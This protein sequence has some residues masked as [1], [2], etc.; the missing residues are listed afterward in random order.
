MGVYGKLLKK[1]YTPPPQQTQPPELPESPEDRKTPVP[2]PLPY[3]HPQPEQHNTPDTVIPRHRD[4]NVD[5]TTPSNHDT[6][7]PRCN[8]V[9]DC[10]GTSPSIINPV[11][12]E[13]HKKRL[14]T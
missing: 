9:L 11:T 2:T 10:N 4:T 1:H 3:E 7:Q 13:K 14:R 6:T 8:L 12:Q 5:T